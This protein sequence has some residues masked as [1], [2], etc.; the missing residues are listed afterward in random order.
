MAKKILTKKKF[1]IVWKNPEKLI[2]YVKNAKIHSEKQINKIALLIS[3]FGFDQPIVIDA[4]GVIIKGHGRREAAIK[5]G[6]K[7]VPV[8][9][10]T[11][12]EFQSIAARLADN[13]VA[14]APWDMDL[15]KFELGTLTRIEDFKIET[16]AFELDMIQ[17]ILKPQTADDL[18]SESQR[19]GQKDLKEEYENSEVRQMILVMSPEQFEELMKKFLELQDIFQLETNLEVVQKL[20]EFYQNANS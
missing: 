15:L 10:S 14:E 2:P 3:E 19:S 9:V 17:D 4:E 20:I 18:F 8:I 13:K 11:L 12:D 7:E 16:T 1:E 5:L 6:M